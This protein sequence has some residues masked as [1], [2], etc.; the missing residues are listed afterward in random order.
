M[1][2]KKSPSPASKEKVDEAI[3]ND[4][5][6]VKLV[7]RLSVA[8]SMVVLL[9]GA[10]VLFDYLAG[11]SEEE[12]TPVFT[13]PVPVG[14]P[15]EITQPVKPAENLPAPPIE[16]ADSKAAPSTEAKESAAVSQEKEKSDASPVVDARKSEKP[17]AQ[18]G[19]AMKNRPVTSN[20]GFTLEGRE[21]LVPPTIVP[22]YPAKRPM[23]ATK[24]VLE[25][26]TQGPQMFERTGDPP[27]AKLLRVVPGGEPMVREVVIPPRGLAGFLLQAGVFSS[28]QRAEELHAK[29]V[30]SGI[31]S[32]LETRVQVGPFKTRQ[33]AEAAQQKLK[34]LGVNTVLLPPTAAH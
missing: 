7:R 6:R 34:A 24:P 2:D 31:P 14:K 28:P 26:S 33:E 20:Q 23:V 13:K 19:D 3:E 5:E 22:A 11:S 12:E 29:L 4:Q 32:T 15:K 25:E 27:N 21:P 18:P 17:I 30:L 8:G 9:L 16:A 10:L 1:T